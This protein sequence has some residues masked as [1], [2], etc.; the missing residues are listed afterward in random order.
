MAPHDMRA[1]LHIC[2]LVFMAI[3]GGWRPAY[4]QGNGTISV[5]VKIAVDPSIGGDVTTAGTATINGVPATIAQTGWTASHA[6]SSPLLVLDAGF[7]VAPRADVIGGFEYGRAEPNLVAIGSVPTGPLSAS[8]D[9]YQFWGL[10][11]GLRVGLEHG[12]GVYGSVTAG[13]RH[14]SA[15][16]AT[17]TAP[18]MTPA[19]KNAYDASSVPTFGVAAGVL[20]GNTSVG[21]GVEVG[22][23]YAGALKGAASSP[24]LAGVETHSQRWS[25]PLAFVVRF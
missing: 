19:V 25:L 21:Y 20:F 1:R 2:L 7:E 22:V 4:A 14:V 15:I 12:H 8:F 17:V 18:G 24:E 11:G 16:G 9:P 3:V 13:F 6:K 5:T 23:K 10:E